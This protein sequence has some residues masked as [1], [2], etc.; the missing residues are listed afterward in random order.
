MLK[1]LMNVSFLPLLIMMSGNLCGQVAGHCGAVDRASTVAVKQEVIRVFNQT[2]DRMESTTP[3]G[4]KAT[5]W[6]GWKTD[7]QQQIKCLGSPAVP[8]IVEQLASSR[9]FGQLLAVKMLGWTGSPEIVAPLS[10]ILK[11]SK[12]HIIKINALESLYSAPETDARPVFESISKSDTDPRI[13]E[14]AA[15]LLLRYSQISSAPR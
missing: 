9:S 7:D 11:E 15:R 12:S 1:K 5:T 3:E 14:S 10:H 4:I 13:R 8:F 2:L 6:T